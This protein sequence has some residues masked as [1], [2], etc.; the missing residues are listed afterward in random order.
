MPLYT[1]N[2]VIAW[3]NPAMYFKKGD[4]AGSRGAARGGPPATVQAPAPQ[5]PLWTARIR[6]RGGPADQPAGAL[7]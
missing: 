4:A 3:S 6:E 2:G 1:S 5:S 7:R